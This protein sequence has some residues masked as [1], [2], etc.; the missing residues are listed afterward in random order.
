MLISSSPLPG[1]K[2]MFYVGY[3]K[4]YGNHK[5]SYYP[6]RSFEE[7]YKE[8]M[9][10][11]SSDPSCEM[12]VASLTVK[13]QFAKNKLLKLGFKQVGRP[14]RNPNSGNRIILLVKNIKK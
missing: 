13:Q 12:V 2:E 3:R 7:V 11:V 5:R 8:K 10:K 6:G 9:G 1:I 14:K 4:D